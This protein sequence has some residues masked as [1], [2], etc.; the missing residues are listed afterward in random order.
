M[1]STIK[2]SSLYFRCFAVEHLELR[3]THRVECFTFVIYYDLKPLNF[4]VQD[5][6]NDLSQNVLSNMSLN[7]QP[8]ENSFLLKTPVPDTEDLPSS[9][10]SEA[11]FFEQNLRRFEEV[12]TLKCDL[13]NNLCVNDFSR[14]KGSNFI[15]AV[16]YGSKLVMILF[17]P[18]AYVLSTIMAHFFL[19]TYC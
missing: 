2:F 6:L 4:S 15:V 17:I 8:M 19:D 12:L 5:D 9:S 11:L 18:G 7:G 3:K 1:L 13:V 16:A 14:C 10:G